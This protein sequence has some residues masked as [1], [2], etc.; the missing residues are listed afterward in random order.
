MSRLYMD[1]VLDSPVPTNSK[2]RLVL[3]AIA[4]DADGAGCSGIT[5][6]ELARQTLIPEATVEKIT[7]GLVADG[8]LEARYPNG[9]EIKYRAFVD[10]MEAADAGGL[11]A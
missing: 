2:R 7:L 9:F 3:A 5:T 6:A 11:A 8:I 1:L 4:H 10:A